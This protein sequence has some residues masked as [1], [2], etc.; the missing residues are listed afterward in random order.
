MWIA[1]ACGA[2]IKDIGDAHRHKGYLL[3]DPD[4]FAASE[5]E[6]AMSPWD[7]RSRARTVYE[8][9]ACGRLWIREGSGPRFRAFL[10]EGRHGPGLL[11]QDGPD[12]GE[13]G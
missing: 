6:A 9:A 2:Q 8:C 7:W 3:S 1:C 11:W 12:P 5:G 4:W 10:P 13:P